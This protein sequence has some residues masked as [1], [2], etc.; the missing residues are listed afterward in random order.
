MKELRSM[1][2]REHVEERLNNAAIIFA[3]LL[4]LAGAIW[5]WYARGNFTL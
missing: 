4:C 1:W 2:D 5:L 3:L